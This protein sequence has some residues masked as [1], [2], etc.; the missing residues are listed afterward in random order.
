M[1][2]IN[3]MLNKTFILFCFLVASIT[4]HAQDKILIYTKNGKGYVHENIAASLE[5]LKKLAADNKFV[6]ES[7]D[8]P[9]VFTA[10]NLKQYKCI[11]FSNT[12][13]EGFD[14]EEQKQAF[15]DYIHAGGGFVGIHSASGSERQWP[16]FWAMLGGKFVRH[17]PLQKFTIKVIDKQHSSTKFLGDTWE[18][19]DECYYTNQL[20]PDIKILLAVDLNTITDEKKGEYPGAVFGTTFPLAWYHEFEGG[21]QFYTSLGHKAEYYKD[22]KYL[23]HLWGGI[24][25]AMGK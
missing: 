23:R 3:T 19:E 10:Q 7:S 9:S 1:I 5:A 4:I 6:A 2:E 15:V 20:N 22:E 24:Q 11:I 18:W 8:Q 14:T 21:R 13:N 16:W 17:P 12:N 25:W